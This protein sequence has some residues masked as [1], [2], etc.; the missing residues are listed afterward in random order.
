MSLIDR[1]VYE[2]GRHLPRKNR[3]DIQAELRSSLIDALEDRAGQEPTEADVAELLKE[4]GPPKVV[5]ASYYPE[6]QYL[7]GPPLYSLFRLV[8]GIVLA[9]VLGAQLL[10]LGIGYF[11]AQEPIAP[12]EAVVGLLNSIPAALGMLVIV[13]VILQWFDVRP[14]T[15][16]EPWDPDSLPEISESETVNRGE[17][18]FGITMSI[19]LLVV[20]GFFPESIGFV[21][22]FGSELFTNPVIAEY[23]GLITFSL[24][25]GIG[26]DIYLL[27]Q[28]RWGTFTRIAKIAANLLSIAILFLLVQGHTAW[29]V[30]H[31]SVGFFATLELLPD[32]ITGGWQVIGMEAF[33]LGFG[34]ALIITSLETVVMIFRLVRANLK[35]GF[36]PETLPSSRV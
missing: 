9:A 24:L 27:W 30:E 35:S 1:Y 33:R 34:V 13:F 4:F 32:N 5:A 19:I 2:V 23:I 10:A 21:T 29:L 25:F 20:L 12:L 17:R 31:G 15:E 28:G 7:I 8:T 3:S 26:L 18:I 11:V 6:G 36:S 22:S 16:D 14:E